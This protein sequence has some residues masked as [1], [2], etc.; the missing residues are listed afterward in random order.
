MASNSPL[1]RAVDGAVEHREHVARIGGDRA[2]RRRRVRPAAR[3][4]PRS[5]P[6]RVRRS[7]RRLVRRRAS[8]S[9]PSMRARSVEQRAAADDRRARQG[10]FET[11]PSARQRSGP[12]PAGSP[13]VTAMLWRRFRACTRRTPRRAGVAAT[14]RFLR[15]PSLRA[16]PR[17]RCWRRTSSVVSNWRRPSNWMMCQPNC[18]RNG[19]LISSGCSCASCF[20]NSGT[21]VPGPAQPRSPPSAAEPGSSE[22]TEA[23]A[24]K[25]SPLLR[26]RSRIDDEL[27]LHRGVVLQLVGLDED[28]A[29]VHLV[30]DDLRV[31]ARSR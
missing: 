6:G 23:T 27:L 10:R 28:V 2:G 4:A 11:A 1:R 22:T 5:A 15:R 25:F 14:A 3:R 12:M 30:D 31:A 17:R 19:W 18:V 21:K 29:R 24:A 16:A 7:R 26:M 8:T 9:Q 20:S 13:A